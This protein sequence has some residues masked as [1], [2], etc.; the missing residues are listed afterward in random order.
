MSRPES[1]HY[2]WISIA[3]HWLGAVALV[4]SF[5]TGHPLEAAIGAERASAYASHELRATILGIPLIARVDAFPAWLA[6]V[7]EKRA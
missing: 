2:G 6:R 3:L 4:A 7:H 1:G 5:V